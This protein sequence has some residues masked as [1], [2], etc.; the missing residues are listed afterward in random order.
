MDEVAGR[1]RRRHAGLVEEVI[2]AATPMGVDP[3]QL[4]EDPAP[5]GPLPASPDPGPLSCDGRQ[6]REGGVFRCSPPPPYVSSDGERLH[7]VTME[8]LARLIFDEIVAGDE[9]IGLHDMET[10]L[11]VAHILDR[12]WAKT[13]PKERAIAATYAAR[14]FARVAFSEFPK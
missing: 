13:K 12:M 2:N 10:H 8:Q 6:I 14:I 9:A 5:A 7:S 3:R 4:V 11:P 1:R